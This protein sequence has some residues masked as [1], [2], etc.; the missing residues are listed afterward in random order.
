V[1]ERGPQSKTDDTDNAE[2]ITMKADSRKIDFR[3]L[4]RDLG[5]ITDVNYLKKEFK[6]IS[7]ELKRIDVQLKVPRAKKA[8]SKLEAR[9]HD[10]LKS[11]NEVQKHLDGNL[12]RLQKDWQKDARVR[13]VV[14]MMSGSSSST[15]SHAKK[16]KKASGK[17]LRGTV[18]KTSTIRK[19]ARAKKG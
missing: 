1:P 7:G 17:R 18:A 12:R 15:K 2:G 19:K 5:R 14:S 11:L 10:L 6:R 3:R 16:T 8:L 13:K 9:F 4:R